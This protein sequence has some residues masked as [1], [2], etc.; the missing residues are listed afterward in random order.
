VDEQ[1][2]PSAPPPRS[3]QPLTARLTCAARGQAKLRK[4]FLQPLKQVASQRAFDARTGKVRAAPAQRGGVRVRGARPLTRAAPGAPAGADVWRRT[5]SHVRARKRGRGLAPGDA[6]RGGGA[7]GCSR[8]LGALRM[9]PTSCRVKLPPL[10]PCCTSRSVV[11]GAIYA[12]ACRQTPWTADD[13][14]EEEGRPEIALPPGT[15]TWMYYATRCCLMYHFHVLGRGWMFS[16]A[17][18]MV[19]HSNKIIFNSKRARRMPHSAVGLG[20]LTT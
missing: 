2:A 7:G 16:L 11:I 3:L 6:E 1:R 9:S 20:C 19:L 18:R 15:C 4:L 8:A 10:L 12:S 17:S 5:R 14:A 13:I